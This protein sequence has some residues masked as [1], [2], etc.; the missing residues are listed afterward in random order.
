MIFKQIPVG[1]DR[2]FAYLIGDEESRQAAVIDPAYTPDQVLAQA[3]TEGLTIRYLINTHDHSD[4]SNGNEYVL[5]ETG[6]ELVLGA[7]KAGLELE[8]GKV[9]LTLIHTPGHTHDCLCIL[10][11][12]PARLDLPGKLVTGDTLFVGKVGG[13]NFE[14]GA[15]TQYASLHEKLMTLPGETEIWPGHDVGVAPSSTIAHE[16]ATNPFLLRKTFEEFVEL[17]RNW[18]AYKKEHGIA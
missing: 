12:Q 2:N 5:E 17:K 8:L 11:T 9:R 1:G 3:A 6:A 18:V 13:T 14:D 15:R 10:A 7:T 4:H 16:I